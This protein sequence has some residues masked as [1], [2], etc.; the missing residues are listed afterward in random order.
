[1]NDFDDRRRLAAIMLI[2]GGVLWL[3]VAIGF[4]PPRLLFALLGLWPLLAI[5]I[6]LDLLIERKPFD[7]PFTAMAIVVMLLIAL[8]RP[9]SAPFEARFVEPIDGAERAQIRLDLASAPTTL[10][11]LVGSDLFRADIVD[12]REVSF[13]RDGGALRS[14]ELEAGGAQ[15]FGPAPGVATSWELRL[16]TGIPVALEVDAAS[17]TVDLDLSGVD[18]ETLALDGGS[19][20]IELTLPATDSTYAAI[21]DFGSGGSNVTTVP[22]AELSVRA[23]TGSGASRWTVAPGTHLSLNLDTGSGSVSIDL[24]DGADILLRVSDDG[25][26]ALRIPDFLERIDGRGDTGTWRSRSSNGAPEIVI[27]V[28]DVGSGALDFR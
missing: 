23:S 1:V 9:G 27:T 10:R 12:R 25:S 13:E 19:G 14:I 18:L 5:G 26:G 16:G 3:L 2:A 22:G 17:G 7:L 21:V 11:P 24:P 20:A 6:G 15:G 4:I 28:E 8:V